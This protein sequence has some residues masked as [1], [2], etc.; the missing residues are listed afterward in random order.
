MR[1]MRLFGALGAALSI[2][3]LFSISPG[4]AATPDAA[5][6]VPLHK[7]LSDYDRNEVAADGLYKDQQVRIRGLVTNMGSVSGGLYLILKDSGEGSGLKLQALFSQDSRERIA[8]LSKGQEVSL[9][10]RVD[11]L[12]MNLMADGCRFLD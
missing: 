4:Y 2:P 8:S 11:H 5:K 9:Q 1:R 7:L 3:V 6:T 10:C 12:L